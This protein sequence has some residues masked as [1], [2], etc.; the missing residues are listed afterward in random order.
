VIRDVTGP[1][2]AGVIH[3]VNWDLRYP[4]P[5]GTARGGGGGGDEGGGGGGPGSEKPGVIQLPVPSHEIGARGPH[6]A[7]GTFTVTLEVDGVAGESRSFE[8]RA[9]PA[10]SVTMTQHKAREAF[11]VEVMEL[12]AKV[13][14]L[15][16][17]LRKRREAATG[18][19]ATKLQAL[20]LRLVGGAGGRGGGRGPSTGSGQVGPPIRQRLGGLQN[21]FI[22]SGA[23]TGTMSA[24]TETMRGALAEA[25]TDLAAIEKDIPK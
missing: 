11:V 16:A 15:G 22:G 3:R 7:P 13:E 1:G 12:Q 2:E 23:R 25:K 4:V 9:D 21:A 14:A 19:E 18:D 8:V 24:P 6:V 5:V 17:D 20:E 10:S